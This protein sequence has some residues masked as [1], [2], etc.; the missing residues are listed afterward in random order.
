[1]AAGRPRH[2]RPAQRGLF[3]CSSPRYYTNH[4]WHIVEILK[5][6]NLSKV[7]GT[8]DTQTSCCPDASRKKGMSYSFRR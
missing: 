2:D 3:E 6:N 7:Y 4:R 1:M 5:V 8:G